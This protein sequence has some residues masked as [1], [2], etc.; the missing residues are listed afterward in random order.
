MD[1]ELLS[2][3]EVDMGFTHGGRKLEDLDD[4]KDTIPLSSEDEDEL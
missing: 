1:D 2:D 3:E 4:F